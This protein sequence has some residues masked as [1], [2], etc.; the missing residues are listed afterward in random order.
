M[1]WR[2]EGRQLAGRADNV[3]DERVAR[4]ELADID[5][6]NM[7]TKNRALHI[8]GLRRNEAC[9][10]LLSRGVREAESVSKW[11]KLQALL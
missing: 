10:G 5:D 11:F 2:E 6:W 3:D 1:V 8:T 4:A 7:V 9:F